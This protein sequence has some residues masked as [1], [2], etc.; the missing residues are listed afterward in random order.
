M[1]CVD[2]KQKAGKLKQQITNGTLR[3]TEAWTDGHAVDDEYVDLDYELA[4]AL[5]NVTEGAARSSVLKVTQVEPCH[6]FVA[7]QALVDG[8]A[9]MSSNDPAVVALHPIL[10]T[11]KRCRDAK[12]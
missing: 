7:W 3:A 12:D 5:A 10:A 6:G 1:G 11:P 9:P 8:C 2:P 4:V